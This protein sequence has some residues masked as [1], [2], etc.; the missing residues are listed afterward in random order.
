MWGQIC[1]ES[2]Y[3]TN[4]NVGFATYK[5]DILI[6]LSQWQYWW[7]FWFS[8]LWSFYYFVIIRTV[9]N[10]LTKMN[11]KMNTS[12]RGRGKW[13]DFIVALIPLSWCGNILLNSNFILRMIEWQNES[14]LFTVRIHG[15]QW[16]WVYKFD[17][18]DAVDI[19]TAPKNI[20]HNRW[21]L[22][23]P[24][25]LAVTDT[26]L[27]AMK[28]RSQLNWLHEYWHEVY[29]KELDT[30]AAIDFNK[31]DLQTLEKPNKIESY[32]T[33]TRVSSVKKNKIVNAIKSID[34]KIAKHS[35]LDSKNSSLLTKQN[36]TLNL[37]AL[38]HSK[39]GF[40]SWNYLYQPK[41]PTPIIS[42]IFDSYDYLYEHMIE[43]IQ[44]NKSTMLKTGIAEVKTPHY[45]KHTNHY[46]TLMN[47]ITSDDVPS[48]TKT[49]ILQSYITT[50]SNYINNLKLFAKNPKNRLIIN[51]KFLNA[52]TFKF[53]DWTWDQTKPI[54]TYIPLNTFKDF[55][56]YVNGHNLLIF[57]LPFERVILNYLSVDSSLV[58]DEFAT[59]VSTSNYKRSFYVTAR[60]NDFNHTLSTKNSI[61]GE[62]A[63]SVSSKVQYILRKDYTDIAPISIFIE[64][65]LVKQDNQLSSDTATWSQFFSKCNS[66][67]GKKVYAPLL[68]MKY[69]REYSNLYDSL[70]EQGPL[71]S[72]QIIINKTNAPVISQEVTKLIDKLKKNTT[73]DLLTLNNSLAMYRERLYFFIYK[74]AHP[75]IDFSKTPEE[76][77]FFSFKDRMWLDSVKDILRLENLKYLLDNQKMK[78]KVK[79]SKMKGELNVRKIDKFTIKP[80]KIKADALIQYDAVNENFFNYPELYKQNI[81]LFSMSSR[82]AHNY[83]YIDLENE[84]DI[85]HN[86]KKKTA[87]GPLR[88]LKNTL[89]TEED[90]SVMLK[91]RFFDANN[92]LEEHLPA[93]SDFLVLKQKRY[94]RKQAIKNTER[95]TINPIDGK[96]AKKAEFQKFYS[97]RVL[98]KMK[99]F[100]NT[101]KFEE[102]DSYTFYKCIRN[103]RKKSDLLPVNLCR[104]L[105]RT[106]KTLVLPAHVNLTVVTNSYD[107]VHS[108]FLPGLGI[109]LD[110]VPGRSTHHSLYLDNIGFYY[111][112]CAE[113]CGRYHH[114]MPIR[115]CALPYEHFVVWWQTKGLPKLLKLNY[116]RTLNREYGYTKFVW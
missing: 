30:N 28:L 97:N 88:I 75:E 33:F 113:I 38:N 116:K 32:N 6:H 79:F 109:K 10:R 44:P 47:I 93:N 67:L 114:H 4:F 78:L 69:E 27:Q 72:K 45:Y 73:F 100:E 106:K 26:Y 98:Y 102:M 8:F 15:K 92:E 37:M 62:L 13:G 39:R 101:L 80:A 34:S 18:K 81:D 22:N 82:A 77:S 29:K 1:T 25:D 89:F 48:K 91:F 104:R 19:M 103:N 21:I 20:G 70:R 3:Q 76:Y 111:G 74:L 12:L 35:S 43:Q 84:W 9:K 23:T 5:S 86:I 60:C 11:P 56:N 66:L 53:S 61:F 49:Q 54:D 14:S 50:R 96:K 24:N 31:T 2:T 112:Q 63:L 108:W 99:A 58:S 105:L 64:D 16:Y 68:A 51:E 85:E 59:G 36:L 110:C 115:V 40:K 46:K 7:W 87:V 65:L 41:F 57:P 52:N 95:Y 55:N 42:K 107:V 90:A 94:K 71:Y 17:L 83:D